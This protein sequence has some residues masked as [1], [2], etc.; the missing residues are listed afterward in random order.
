MSNKSRDLLR[1]TD[2][3]IRRIFPTMM[4]AN[5]E[6]ILTIEFYGGFEFFNTRRYHNYETWSEGYRVTAGDRFDNL[7]ATAEDLDDALMLFKK[8]LADWLL[9]QDE[10]FLAHYGIYTPKGLN[11]KVTWLRGKTNE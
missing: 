6:V 11:E 1:E 10:K 3:E 5:N 8:Q 4:W 9:E 7:S 2:L